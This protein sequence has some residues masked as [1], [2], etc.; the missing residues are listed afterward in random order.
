LVYRLSPDK[1]TAAVPAIMTAVIFLVLPLHVS[2]VANIKNRDGLLSF[3]WGMTF[4]HLL[5]SFFQPQSAI[6]KASYV[7]LAAICLYLSIYS[8]LDAF[9]F[10]LISPFFLL[11]YNQKINWKNLLR[12]SLILLFLYRVIQFLFT[13]WHQMK[14][15]ATEGTIGN[16]G[17][18]IF[19]ENPLV[20]VNDFSTKLSYTIQT[21][22]EYILMVFQPSGHYFYFGYDMLPITALFSLGTFLKGMLILISI[23][24]ALYYFKR[25]PLISFGIYVFY[26]AQIYCSN[27][28]TPVA[29]IV[30]DRYIFIASAGASIVL[31]LLLYQASLALHKRYF[32]K[33]LPPLQKSKQKALPKKAAFQIE[34]WHLALG[35][36]ALIF[37]FYLPFNIS[38]AKDWKDIFTLI[39]ADLPK[40]T[41]RSFQANRIAMKN[42]IE[43]AYEIEDPNVRALYFGKALA[44]G[45]NA[46]AIYDQN[47]LVNEG[48][49]MAYYGLGNFDNAVAQSRAVIAQFDSSEVSYRILTEY[50]YMN[51]KLDSAALGY[52]R[53]IELVPSDPNP[54]LFYITTLQEGGRMAD[55]LAYTDT[56]ESNLIFPYL[57]YQ[58]RAYLYLNQK[59]S[60]NAVLNIEK[61]FEKGWRDTQMLDVMGAYWWTRDQKKWADLKKYLN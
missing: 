36:T 52:R 43:T 57:A 2:M 45:Q 60:V 48:M 33:D 30:A 28:I 6:K 14:D 61:G 21:I 49:V 41:H 46:I 4:L 22:F 9:G 5:I 51:K 40:I 3:F 38:R 1:A 15:Q 44:Y 31:A 55:A 26:V 25:Q 19:T 53:L 34:Q 24:L 54:A 42:Y 37:F 13:Q 11:F 59:D 20:D 29:G 27:F 10:L 35:I 50:F 39:E 8:K 56:L 18:L 58:G 47:M 7:L 12:V 23:G 32:Q 17:E 16:T